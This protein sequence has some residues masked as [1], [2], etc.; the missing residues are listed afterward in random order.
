MAK[1]KVAIILPADWWDQSYSLCSV[2]EN[3][4]RG[5]VKNGYTPI[6]VTLQ[7]FRG[8]IPVPGIEHRKA[9]PMLNLVDYSNNREL[10]KDF[11]QDVGHIKRAL[12]E[13][14]SD[15][16]HVITHDLIFQGWFLPHNVACRRANLNVK[17][18]HWIHSAPAPT[19]M[20]KYPFDHFQFLKP[21]E[22]L[23]YLNEI[24]LVKAAEKYH[25]LPSRVRCVPNSIDLRTFGGLHPFTE[26]LIDRFDLFSADVLSVY[27]LSSTR[28][29][30]GKQVHKAVKV[31][32]KLKKLYGIK[33]KFIIANA[34]ANAQKEKQTIEE[35]QAKF[36]DWGLSPEEVIFTSI[37]KTPEYE[38]GVPRK[39]VSDLFRMSN[40]FVFP[41]IS[42]N[43]SLVLLEAALSG[44]L[45]ALNKNFLPM[46]AQLGNLAH[47][48]E[49]SSLTENVQYQNEEGYYEDV[50]KIMWD[51]LQKNNA[52][53]SKM[54]IQKNFNL[55]YL[56]RHKIEGLLY[57]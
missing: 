20:E 21:N 4:L 11:E 31:H 10:H 28:M 45:C 51:S 29:V 37:Q 47:Y 7:K 9:L 8:D 5:F 24:D 46:R 2:V 53:M 56:F 32:E 55:D 35:L 38:L 57:E 48:F 16:T 17:W 36:L 12:E 23:I 44:N 54:H 22:T 3:Q 52:L 30:D 27:P 6:I 26:Y 14:L 18:L 43:C 40:L 34:H 42:E 19:D 49:F 41:S 33:T 1:P 25:V 39:V 13:S 15:V 50:A